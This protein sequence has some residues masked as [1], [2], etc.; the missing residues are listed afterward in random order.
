M[1][2]ETVTSQLETQTTQVISSNGNERVA[3]SSSQVS[4]SSEVLAL[5]KAET[6]LFVWLFFLAVGGGILALYY[7]R[8]GYLP[9]IEWS[10]IL[11]Y[12][13]AATIIGGAIGLLLVMSLFL[14]GFIWSEFLIFEPKWRSQL[15]YSRTEPCVQTTM[16]H[17]GLPFGIALLL[18]HL[19]LGIALL[20]VSQRTVLL[21]YAYVSIAL[22]V[23]AA[24][25][26]W[27]IYSSDAKAAGVADE[28]RP[29]RAF[30][31]AA[32]FTLSLLLSQLSI[33][34]MY[35]LS[36]PEG[37]SN[38]FALTAICTFGCLITTHVVAILYHYHKTPAI[39][40][41]LVAAGFLLLAADR[42]SPLSERIMGY[43][44]WGRGQTV[45]LVLTA[46]GSQIAKDLAFSTSSVAGS[47]NATLSKV[48][49]LSCVGDQY[50]LRVDKKT[51]VLPKSK[52][53]SYQRE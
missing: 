49:I 40:A 25:Y 15:C 51:F 13:A 39:V 28:E 46:E 24:I 47:T 35:M 17:L 53:L 22:L 10:S 30:K 2:N 42:F 19:S 1:S 32:W 36:E 48:E 38:F 3:T 34:V 5:F 45:T 44:G 6:T 27:T 7:A 31:C 9:D 33:I 26:M 11:I 12:L 18:S 21:T 37:A 20:N 29:L 52:V 8:I 16:S 4:T 43:Y 23:G 50:F 14:P 41:A